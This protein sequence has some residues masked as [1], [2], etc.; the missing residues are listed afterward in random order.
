[1]TYQMDPEQM[2]EANYWASQ[3]D[4]RERYAATA[5]DMEAFNRSEAEAE[6][7]DEAK[8]WFAQTFPEA[9]EP[10]DTE[11]LLAEARAAW[12]EAE[13][14]RVAYLARR[15]DAQARASEAYFRAHPEELP[16]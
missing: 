3:D 7:L 16:F 11:A 10:E 2:E 5:A 12:A 1:M 9:D 8:A 14:R 13:A 6:E 4:V 15:A